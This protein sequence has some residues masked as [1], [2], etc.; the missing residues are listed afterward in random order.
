MMKK[1]TDND[2]NQTYLED[3]YVFKMNQTMAKNGGDANKAKASVN[4]YISKVRKYMDYVGQDIIES[5]LNS[6]M[7]WSELHT[8]TV[9]NRG[10]GGTNAKSLNHVRGFMKDLL[11]MNEHEEQKRI[12]REL[13]IYLSIN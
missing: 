5:P 2:M 9:G 10:N 12:S 1:Y 4:Q 8:V 3:Y 13:L 11:R 7:G 6:L